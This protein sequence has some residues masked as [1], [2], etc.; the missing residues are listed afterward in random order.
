RPGRVASSVFMPR[1]FAGSGQLDG[2]AQSVGLGVD[3]VVEVEGDTGVADAHGA[4]L[5]AID[6]P[7]CLF[8]GDDQRAALGGEGDLAVAA[9]H[10]RVGLEGGGPELQ[11]VNA[12]DGSALIE[13]VDR[14]ERH[15]DLDRVRTA[16]VG[17]GL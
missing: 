3:V 6:G 5:G 1:S 14:L 13:Q 2:V 7:A 11:G 10:A 17:G 12:L 9:P 15:A 8:V 16:D 4:A